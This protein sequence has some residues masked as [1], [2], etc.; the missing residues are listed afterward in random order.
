[1]K[2]IKVKIAKL[3]VKKSV[4]RELEFRRIVDSNDILK[5]TSIKN[6]CVRLKGVG[7]IMEEFVEVV[8]EE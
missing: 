3:N 7:Y 2:N 4:S 1:M 5:Y 8:E 6:G